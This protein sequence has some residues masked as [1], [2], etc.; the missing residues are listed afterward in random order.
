MVGSAQVLHIVTLVMIA[1][2]GSEGLQLLELCWL[3]F[4]VLQAQLLARLS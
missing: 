2:K 4:D 3:L 1:H